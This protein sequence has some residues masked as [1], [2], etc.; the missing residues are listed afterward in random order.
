MNSNRKI[1]R[2]LK[3]KLTVNL[4]R[5]SFTQSNNYAFFFSLFLSQRISWSKLIRVS[6]WKPW[7]SSNNQLKGVNNQSTLMEK[8]SFITYLW[9]FPSTKVDQITFLGTTN[10]TNRLLWRHIAVV[11]SASGLTLFTWTEQCGQWWLRERTQLLNQPL[12]KLASDIELQENYLQTNS[13]AAW[14]SSNFLW[15]DINARR[16]SQL[17]EQL[18]LN[19]T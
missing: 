16:S 5:H 2:L 14:H 6:H 18:S 12:T 19:T 4:I 11:Q 7:Q 15:K 3:I 17:N 9:F 13:K 8:N 10:A 1:T